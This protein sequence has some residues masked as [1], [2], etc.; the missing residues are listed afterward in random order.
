MDYLGRIITKNQ[1]APTGGLT[2]V[3]NG[4]WTMQQVA[5]AKAASTWPV[6]STTVIESFTSSTTWV[7]PT[8]VTAVE[9][10]VVAGGGGGGVSAVVVAGRVD[11]KLLQV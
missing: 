8:G 1:T 2:G 9:Y 3:A 4:I 6:V 5:A 7:A 10:L 11:L